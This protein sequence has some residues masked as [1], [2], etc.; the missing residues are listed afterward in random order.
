MAKAAEVGR[1]AVQLNPNESIP[2][3]NLVW[4]TLGAGEFEESE[5]ELHAL[6]ELDPEYWD[7]YVCK[8]LVELAQGRSNE[9]SQTYEQLAFQNDYGASLAST[10]LA[11]LACYEGR[12]SDA[13]EA[14]EKGVAFDLEK[15]Q[16]YIA[17]DKYMALA[18][19]HLLLEKNDIAVQMAESALASYESEELQFAAAQIYARAGQEDKARNLAGELRLSIE[20]INRAYA[21]LVGGELSMARGDVAGAIELFLEAQG[22]VDTWLSHF[23][24]GQAYLKAEAYSEAYSEFNTCLSRRGEAA[25]VFFSDLPTY[26]F[27]PPVFYYLGRAQEGLKS[28]KA[29]DSYNAF[30]ILKEK[31]DGDWMV[32]DARRRLNDL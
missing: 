32:E 26:R 21:R 14:L 19:I 28:D 29:A 1:R 25:S 22:I 27:L 5:K 6:I 18:N 9:A 11:D 3:Y 10:G 17:A 24:L 31:G 13:R 16:K 30:L 15:G 23:L 7:V 8:A 20:P 12:L 4:Y 2:R